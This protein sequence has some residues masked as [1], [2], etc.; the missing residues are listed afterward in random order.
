MI[1]VYQHHKLL[2]LISIFFVQLYIPK[3]YM[4]FNLSVTP[5]FFLIYLTYLSTYNSRLTLIVMGFSLGFIQDIISQHYL[6]GL[7]AFSKTITGFILGTFHKHNKIWKKNIK[8]F[9]LF[10]T[11]MFHFILSSY[12]M[13]E[14]SLTPISYILKISFMESIWMILILYII[15]K[16]ILIDNKIID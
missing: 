16:F 14:R 10:S 4:G 15:N 5:D 1:S 11:Y 13:F 12:F 2:I 6:L 3:I 9:F 7:F 8:L